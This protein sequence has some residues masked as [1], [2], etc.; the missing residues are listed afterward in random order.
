MFDLVRNRA[1]IVSRFRLLIVSV[2]TLVSICACNE[3]AQP[4]AVEAAP[5]N[6]SSPDDAGKGLFEAAKSGNQEAV[7]AI[8]GHG[9]KELIYTGNAAEFKC[10]LDFGEGNSSTDADINFLGLS[11]HS[12]DEIFKAPAYFL[13]TVH[14]LKGLSASY[15]R[16]SSS[17]PMG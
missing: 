10:A 11:L 2:A 9:A 8:F 6:F 1:S 3:K 7:V 15:A 14:C 17:T 5:K 16:S 13:E 4:P 12:S